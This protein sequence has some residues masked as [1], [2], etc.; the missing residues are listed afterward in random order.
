MPNLDHGLHQNLRNTLVNVSM[1][2]SFNPSKPFCHC[3]EIGTP[4][5]KKALILPPF[6]SLTSFSIRLYLLLDLALRDLF[7]FVNKFCIAD[8]SVTLKLGAQALINSIVLYS[9]TPLP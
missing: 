2:S 9:D 1:C 6:R 8:P 7:H 4:V 3:N 5:C